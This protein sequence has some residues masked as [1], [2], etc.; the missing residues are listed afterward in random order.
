MA[1]LF[2]NKA[3][4]EELMNYEVPDFDNKL[5][6]IKQWL[7][8]YKNG[9]LKEKTENQCE[10]AFNQSFFVEILG[11]TPFPNEVYTI[12]P[13]GTTDATGQKPDAI[14]G[15][16]D[17]DIKRTIAVVEIKNAKTALDKS[18]QREGNL[19]PV[20]QAF[21]YK[22]QFKDCT[23]VIATNFI[24]IRLLKDN[25]L[26]YENFTLESLAD[27]K[28]DYFELK[29]F[30]YLLSADN[31]IKKIGKTNTESILSNIRIEE[32]KIT[33]KFYKEYKGLR[34]EL[35]K[36]ILSNLPNGKTNDFPKVVQQAQK[37]I[38]RIV[39]ICFCEDLGLIPQ[40]KLIE[41]IKYGQNSPLPPPIWD[42]MKQFFTAIDKG[43]DKLGIPDGYNGEL[44]KEDSELNSLKIS[45]DIC[46]KFAEL[47]KY[48][49][50]ED[51][52]VNILGHIFE[53]SISDLEELKNIGNTEENKETSKRKKDGIFY[54]PEYIVD[55]IVINS[56]GEYLKNIERNILA[57][58][59]LKEGIQ[60]KN[61]NKRAT[62]AY[63]EYREALEKVKVLDP[64]CGSGA[65]LVK[66]FDFL[67]SE[68]KRVNN[69]LEDLQGTKDMFSTN[70]Y[71]KS[72]LQN[73]IYG[74]DINP[75]S[76][77]ITKLSLWL[78]TAN[79]GQKLVIL[80]DN[81]KCGN[82]LI[83]DPLVAGKSTFKWEEEFK[84]IMD[85]GGFDVVIGNP[86][87]LRLQGLRT[88]FK[89]ET[90]YYENEYISAT[91]RFDIYVLFIE[92]SFKLISNN[93]KVGFILPHKFMVSDFGVGTRKLL[94]DLKG[95]ESIVSFGSE[96]V[97]SDASTYTCILILSK[98]NLEFKYKE[99]RP[100]DI[101]LPFEFEQ[102]KT[103]SLSSEKWSL[104]SGTNANLIDKIKNQEFKISDLFKNISQGIV[105]VGDDIF[106]MKGL[107][108]DGK[109][110]G[111]SERTNSE[112]RLEKDIMKPI[113]KG[114]DVKKYSSLS[115][116]YYIIYPHYNSDGK[117]KP[118]E[119]DEFK[120]KFPL[121]YNYLFEFKSELINK[122]IRYKT[123]TKYWYSLHR[124]REIVL[125]ENTIKIVTPE[126]SL[127]TNMTLDKFG[128]YHNTQVYSLVAKDSISASY[129]YLLAVLNSKIMWFF[130]SK[131]GTVLRGGYFR[132][133]TKYLEPFAMPI[134]DASYQSVI[135]EKV[136]QIMII[137]NDLEKL[138]SNTISNINHEYNLKKYSKKLQSFWKLDF[139]EFIKELKTTKISL[140]KKSELITFF[141]ERKKEALE[142][143]TKIDT[144]D[145]EMDS[146]IFD[147]YELTEDERQIVLDS[148]K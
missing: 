136:N 23:F 139:D 4:K 7:D 28:D 93:G 32:E 41:V 37:I 67:L 35:I 43:S 59:N 39:F 72:I 6:I 97:F 86:P 107:I 84:E 114:D 45:D 87:Y 61:Y 105:S 77:E 31:F 55:Y 141:E 18:Q 16:Y 116:D 89:K 53:Q 73:N 22:P 11:Y 13:K 143:K 120:N 128:Y 10:Q 15:Y 27:S 126:T 127:G 94:S 20:Q 70:E 123:N 34:K 66:V 25:Q 104:Q 71:I 100:H 99:I 115:A 50:A 96:M 147:L 29:K 40:D 21:K 85:N 60:D 98:N 145:E 5:K 63:I 108:K 125:F 9:N 106:I 119:E 74:V 137:T 111:Y 33:K 68:H 88:N 76:V 133:K 52:S 118:Y 82:S 46:K 113:L 138:I 81:I 103:S 134:P 58:N 122:K 54:T 42:T 38:D 132:Y 79:K 90:D 62:K 124:S 49:F 109:F 140:D 95:V 65:F 92:K 30:Y 101:N 51:L 14:L 12:E 26:D 57:D 1:Q 112:I 44:F 102:I 19:S 64:A 75:E 56:L 83:D 69:I 131:T 110:L 130:L 8:A 47:G 17:N 117:T 121:A 142:L 3:L 24:E 91:G 36:D 146:M 148:T 80:K 135:S 48:D 144:L 78:K 2:K 129:E